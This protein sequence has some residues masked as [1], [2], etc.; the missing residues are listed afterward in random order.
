LRD[1]KVNLLDHE[2]LDKQLNIQLW[3]KPTENGSRDA[4]GK[5]PSW[6][7]ITHQPRIQNCFKDLDYDPSPDICRWEV[8]EKLNGCSMT[9]FYDAEATP[10]NESGVCSHRVQVGAG[11][12]FWQAAMN[13]ELCWKA[14][15]MA[16]VMGVPRVALQGELVGKGLPSNQHFIPGHPEFF[17][18][19]IIIER[20]SGKPFH[21]MP[22]HRRAIAEDFAISHVPVINSHA[23]L[24]GS[25]A[26]F[27]AQADS[28]EP[29]LKNR[30]YYLPEGVVYKTYQ[31]L[32]KF[33]RV[34]NFKVI[35]NKFLLKE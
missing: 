16:E 25:V 7:S 28:L 24:L 11:N 27:L 32:D 26:E 3:E 8:T 12:L 2:N 30:G 1:V 14:K 10:G 23:R 4:I 20:S 35:S 19:D 33:R 34:T 9:V 17:L 15:E 18:F 13:Q 29:G 31:G 22:S 21:M 5:I 6:I